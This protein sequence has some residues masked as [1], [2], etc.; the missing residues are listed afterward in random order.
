MKKRSPRVVAMGRKPRLAWVGQRISA[1]VITAKP[2]PTAPKNSAVCQ[3][4]AIQAITPVPWRS[5]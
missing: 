5:P 4:H 2:R 1:S 3:V